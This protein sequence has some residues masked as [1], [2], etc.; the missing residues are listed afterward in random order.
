MQD[1][2]YTRRALLWA[3]GFA[4]FAVLCRQAPYYPPF[5]GTDLVWHLMPVGAL[6]LFVGSRLRSGWAFAVP[7]AVMLLS[8]LLLIGPLSQLPEPQRAL[9]WGRLPIYA[10]FLLAV[11]I[12]RGLRRDES[13][14]WVIGGAT[15]LGSLQFFVVTNLAVWVAGAGLRRP[16]TLAGLMQCYADA[17]P[18]FGNTVLGDLAFT[19]LFFAL[20][21]ATELA[22]A[23]RAAPALGR[24][25][26]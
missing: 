4:L 13:S 8:D 26:A 14:P 25:P 9:G 1:P 11:L 24:Q 23:R 21:G 2:K 7:L 18:F 12:G 17:L 20:H 22:L 3:A 5:R 6:S 16:H 15:L 10:S 19:A